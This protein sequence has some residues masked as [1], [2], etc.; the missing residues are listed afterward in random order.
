MAAVTRYYF[1]HIPKTAGVTKAYGL[2]PKFFAPAEIC[3]HVTF[4]ALL[5]ISAEERAKY[6][7][8]HG[9]FY[10]HLPHF[11]PEPLNVLT[12][13]RH[14]FERAISHYR[15]ILSSPAHPL[16]GPVSAAPDFGAYLRDRRLF[17]PNSLT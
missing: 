13:L 14:P 12:L 10:N 9:H 7:L 16:H 8:F 4:D 5:G 15:Y 17:A 6:R 1:F 2:L 11:L 3:P